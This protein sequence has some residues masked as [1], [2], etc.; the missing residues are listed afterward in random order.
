MD[1]GARVGMTEKFILDATAGFR[2]MWFNKK[3]PNC[4]YLDQRPECEPDVIGD[5]RN[6]KDFADSSF[7]FI[8][9]DPPHIL[10]SDKLATMG[11]VRMFGCL[12]KETWQSDLKQAFKELWRVLKDYGI[13]VLKWSNTDVSSHE[14]LKL[15]N[16]EPLLYQVT[17]ARYRSVDGSRKKSHSGM[18]RVQTMWFCFM[19]IPE[20]KT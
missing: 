7:R 17:S 20:A 14:I 15:C 13:L 10:K 4:I 11:M 16:H 18:D 12:E 6:L 3:H 8:V 1:K 2:M 5:Y 9:F 19:K